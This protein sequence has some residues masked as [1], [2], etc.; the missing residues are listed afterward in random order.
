MQEKHLSIREFRERYENGEFAD[1]SF[2][3]QVAAGW[4]DWF[5][6]ESR[7]AGRLK[8]LWDEIISRITDDKVLDAYTIHFCNVCP[9]SEH[10]LFDRIY[11]SRIGSGYCI[12]IDVNDKRSRHRFNIS[13]SGEKDYQTDSADDAAAFT[14]E[15][16][17]RHLSGAAPIKKE[18]DKETEE[19]I[20][21]ALRLIRDT[22]ED[23]R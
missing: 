12:C 13:P 21:K 1:S 3:T 18:P 22:E 15:A 11:L 7:L 23:D 4:Y 14:E 5:C 6:P 20:Q 10:P 19:L 16:L 17:R 2:D 8:R 9:A